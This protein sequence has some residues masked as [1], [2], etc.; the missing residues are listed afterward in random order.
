MA[1]EDRRYGDRGAGKGDFEGRDL[2]VGRPEGP[3]RAGG[4]TTGSGQQPRAFPL[5]VGAGDRVRLRRRSA[6]SSPSSPD[7]ARASRTRKAG[8]PSA[9]IS[10]PGSRSSSA[11]L[12]RSRS[13]TRSCRLRC[14]SSVRTRRGPTAPP[15]SASPPCRARAKKYP[16]R[17]RLV[18]E[19]GS[20]LER[21][22]ELSG[23]PAR[24]IARRGIRREVLRKVSISLGNHPGAHPGGKR[25][26]R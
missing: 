9:D 7:R 16:L 26:R 8:A 3:A 15:S 19:D 2:L 24:E 20:D 17:L 23:E 14:S 22:E 18:A 21:A 12:Q 5:G 11:W 13:V 10:V 25:K 6:R 4:P 1:P